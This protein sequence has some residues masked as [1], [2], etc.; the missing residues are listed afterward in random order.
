MLR[1]QKRTMVQLKNYTENPHFRR[2]GLSSSWKK[3]NSVPNIV[4]GDSFKHISWK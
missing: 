3:I 2:V 4:C 1:R